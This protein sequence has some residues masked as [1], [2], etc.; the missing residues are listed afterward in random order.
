MQV[1]TKASSDRNDKANFGLNLI[2]T[3]CVGID[4]DAKN[5]ILFTI[6]IVFIN[7]ARYF[8]RYNNKVPRLAL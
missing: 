1:Y 5:N 7:V 6:F 2:L 3:D 4:V 8:G